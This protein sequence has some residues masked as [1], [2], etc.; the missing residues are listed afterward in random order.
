MNK[1]DE[2]QLEVAIGRVLRVAVLLSST[3]LAFGLAM[4]L[5]SPGSGELLLR[6]GIVA[7][8]AGPPSRVFLTW[9]GSLI[10]RDRTFVILTSL[11]L[12][13][14]GASVIAAMVFNRRL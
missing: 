10:Q 12:L 13:E 4:E 9:I 8:I 2:H 5:A 7:L 3:C 11:V 1:V 6:V 14:M